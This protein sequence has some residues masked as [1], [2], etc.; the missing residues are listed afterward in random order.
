MKKIIP[1]ISM[2]VLLSFCSEEKK[3]IRRAANSVER[4]DFDKAISYY[5]QVLQKN[6][7]SFFGN[8]GKGVVLSEFMAR[9]EQA[10]PYLETALKN[11]PDKTKPILHSNLGRSYHFVGNFER[12]LFYYKEYQ[13]E[14][15]P[16]WADYDEFLTKRIADC[17]YAIEHPKIALPEHQSIKNIGS[18]VN[19]DMPEYTP[20]FANG[21]LIFTSK[22][23]D[24]EKEKKN[25]ID[26]R[27]YE[28]I[29]T[30]KLENGVFSTPTRYELS[31]SATRL[32][33]SGEAV[34]SIS[35]D[36]TKLF[37]YKGGK[38]YEQEANN[39]ESKP[40]KMDKTINFNSLQN[41][42]SLSPD[43]KELYFTNAG[44]DGPG[45]SDI[46]VSVKGDDGKWSD[47]KLLDPIINT[48]F[49][50]E[51]PYINQNG[52][53]FFA[54]NGHPGYGGFDIYKTKKVN[55]S[56]TKPENLGQP[57]NSPG[58]DIYFAMQNN[59]SKGYYASARPGGFGDLDIY[60]VHYVSTETTPCN[61]Q[62][63]ILVI[64]TVPDGMD[65][66][67]YNIQLKLPEEYKNNVRSF[68]WEVNGEPVAETGNSFKHTFKKPNDYK[69]TAQLV[70]Y[71]DTCP[72]LIGMCAEKNISIDNRVLAS[73]SNSGNENGLNN[74]TQNKNSKNTL[75]SKNNKNSK[76]GNGSKTIAQNN[77]SNTAGANPNEF[78]D[79]NDNS[80]TSGGTSENALRAGNKANKSASP[81]L[82]YLSDDELNEINWNVSAAYFDYD[83][84]TLRNDAKAVIDQNIYVM[85]NKENIWVNL[86]G[87]ADSRGSAEYNRALSAKRVNSVKQYL[88]SKGIP[89]SR[90]KETHAY[91]ESQLVNH[92]SDGVEC[93]ESEHQKNRRV[94][95]DVLQSVK[96]PGSI[97][98]N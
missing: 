29:Y 10:I 55:G 49:D 18:T 82:T 31:K 7:N 27:Y 1:L 15:D 43:G 89:A 75:A 35:A 54:S 57:I 8:A 41:H 34:L 24:S 79:S 71:C 25:G 61:F 19:T 37:V 73:N 22:R 12:A 87:Y 42:A 74:L 47:P 6:Q 84:Y 53:L 50:E 92:C 96:A 38:I 59:S 85:Q 65:P 62:D 21:N 95:F 58:D 88:I 81:S 40:Q 20:V 78:E 17:R 48:S 60:E 46:Y 66:L 11:T 45:G 72:Q 26:G 9:H 76:S 98:S 68:R 39:P 97:T 86:S 52:E 5:D 51:S 63:S 90:I 33:R 28:A 4:S 3:L 36:G 32:R 23:K 94:K 77:R 30:S 56:W 69:V 14:N 44:G 16:K 91:G 64:N 80:K 67:S 13:K 2:A 83:D 70:V 93:D